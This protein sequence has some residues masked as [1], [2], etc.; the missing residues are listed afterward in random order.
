MENIYI[1]KWVCTVNNNENIQ[2]INT[3]INKKILKSA[4][5]K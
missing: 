4:I 1:W 2:N 3:F 5:E